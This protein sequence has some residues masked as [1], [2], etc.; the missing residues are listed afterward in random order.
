MT[1]TEVKEIIDTDVKVEPHISVANVLVNTHLQG[2]GL[3]QL[4]LKEIE[5]WLSAHFVAIQDP[6]AV[7]EGASELRQDFGLYKGKGLN[8][9]EYGQQAIV[10]DHTGTLASLGGK[11]VTFGVI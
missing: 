2:K 8:N 10:L 5:R 1:A 3:P 9:S 4:L 6:R 11:K 7:S